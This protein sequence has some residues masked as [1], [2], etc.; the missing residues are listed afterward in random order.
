MGMI[1]TV[2]RKLVCCRNVLLVKAAQTLRTLRLTDMQTI[3]SVTIALKIVS[4]P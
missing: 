3:L 1:T 4:Q 2:R